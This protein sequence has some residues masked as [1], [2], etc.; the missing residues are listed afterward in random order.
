MPSTTRGS[1]KPGSRTSCRSRMPSCSPSGSSK[2]RW[3]RWWRMWSRS[4][5]VRCGTRSQPSVTV[6]SLSKR[7]S[8]W[9]AATAHSGV[10]PTVVRALPFH[11]IRPPC[12]TAASLQGLLTRPCHTGF[13]PQINVGQSSPGGCPRPR[14]PRKRIP[15]CPRRWPTP[16]VIFPFPQVVQIRLG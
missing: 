3:T 6:W 5:R 1:S 16:S 11:I 9:A 10:P 4:G 2:K 7:P 13:L 14:G 8:S 12:R 15:S